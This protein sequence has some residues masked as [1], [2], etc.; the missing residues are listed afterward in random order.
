MIEYILFVLFAFLFSYYF[1]PK[2]MNY[3]YGSFIIGSDQ[4][5]PNK[6]VLATS[7]GISIL[8]SFVITI[9]LYAIYLNFY[10]LHVYTTLILFSILLSTIIGTLIG[11]MDDI[12]T[13]SKQQISSSQH[14]DYRVGLSQ[15]S[16]LILTMLAS[17]PII[18]LVSNTSIWFPI[19]G[20]I[21]FLWI[22]SFILIPLA[23]LGCIS[24]A[25]ALEGFNGIATGGFTIIFSFLTIMFLLKQ[26]IL[27]AFISLIAA[28]ISFTAYLYNKFPAKYLPGDSTTFFFG[29][30]FCTLIIL[31]KLEFYGIIIFLPWI[32]DVVVYKIPHKLKSKWMAKVD[33]N[34]I[35]KPITGK[36]ETLCQQFM[37]L[38]DY[39]E[40]HLVFLIHLFI[41]LCCLIS[42][43][44]FLFVY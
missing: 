40:E 32:I 11:F 16:K 39:T 36:V 6:P 26:N 31:G 8:F 27:L 17:L 43:I 33:S 18:P 19:I 9:L 12:G 13:K 38:G 28:T 23:Y 41:L 10:E 21:N 4:H 34:G 37:V 3:L 7:L 20:E 35:L 24:G 15:K 29:S 44:V 42:M 25:N 5:K 22:Y 30:L 14:I 2:I 1:T